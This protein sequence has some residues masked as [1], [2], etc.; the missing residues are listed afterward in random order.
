MASTCSAGLYDVGLITILLH[1]NATAVLYLFSA[2][3]GAK[4]MP[5]FC[6]ETHENPVR[7]TK[8]DA[9]PDRHKNN[10]LSLVNQI[11]TRYAQLKDFPPH[12]SRLFVRQPTHPRRFTPRTNELRGNRWN[13]CEGKEMQLGPQCTG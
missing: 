10:I 1:F 6:L 3:N 12:E 4:G 11:K 9:V 5:P 8:P 7:D 13:D 2:L